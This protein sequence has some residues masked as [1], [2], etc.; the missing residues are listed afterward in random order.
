MFFKKTN[1]H[2]LCDIV[3]KKSSNLSR[4]ISY[5]RTAQGRII[6]IFLYLGGKD[7]SIIVEISRATEEFRIE[8]D[9]SL[10][11][12]GS[13]TIQI[14]VNI[15]GTTG[16]AHY[17]LE[18]CEKPKLGLTLEEP[19]FE[20]W[21]WLRNQLDIIADWLEDEK[22]V[23]IAPYTG[24]ILTKDWTDADLS[25]ERN[26]D[27]LGKIRENLHNTSFTPGIHNID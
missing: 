24:K 15:T 18:K 2:R 25:L 21:K 17:T 26:L 16:F 10:F 1:L 4:T 12:D 23:R 20:N 3:I 9:Y 6:K 19:R 14:T 13:C 22:T 5:Y 8:E 11:P 27:A 7:P